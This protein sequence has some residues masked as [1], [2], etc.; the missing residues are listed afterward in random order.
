M[1]VN[2]Y[3][4]NWD[5]TVKYYVLINVLCGRL[6]RL[7]LYKTFTNNMLIK[8]IHLISSQGSSF[9]PESHGDK[10]TNRL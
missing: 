8:P 3:P 10:D 2:K 4:Q 1:M 6:C 7:Q 5:N 9:S